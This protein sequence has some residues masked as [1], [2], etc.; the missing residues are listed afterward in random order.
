MQIETATCRRPTIDRFT[1]VEMIRGVFA[2]SPIFRDA[3]VSAPVTSPGGG[4][5]VHLSLGPGPGTLL[6][7]APSEN[8]AY[9]ILHELVSTMAEIA[10]YNR[11]GSPA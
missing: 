8:E 3:A 1:F 4:V 6:V 10:P 9:A 11:D 5:T 7:T 2:R